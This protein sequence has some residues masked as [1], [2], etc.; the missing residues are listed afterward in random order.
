MFAAHQTLSHLV[1]LAAAAAAVALTAGPAT[2]A[3]DPISI[4][5]PAGEACE[6]FAV[7]L[8]IS[9]GNR[10]T[11]E[12]TDRSGNTVVLTTGAADTVLV[13]RLEDGKPVGEP[14]RVPA[15]GARTKVVTAPDG[16]STFTQT[17]NLLLVLFSSDMGNGILDI[18]STTLIAGRTV[19]TVGE[20]GAFDLQSV[21]GRTTDICEVLAT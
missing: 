13:T 5:L 12:F 11:R 14:V 15:R 16:T 21:T 7:S 8:D 9:G 18:P 2:A 1:A 20:D 4:D 3:V 19:F 6:D 10:K 17:G